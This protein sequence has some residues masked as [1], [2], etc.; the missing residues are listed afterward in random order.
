MS[1]MPAGIQID[2]EFSAG[3][4][5]NVTQY[6]KSTEGVSIKL[7]RTS[8]F[9]QPQVATCSVVL[10]NRTGNFTPLNAGGAYYPNV[11]P[12]KRIRVSYGSGASV[13]F[14][15]RIM[16][17]TPVVAGALYPQVRVEA[18]D[19]LNVLAGKTITGTLLDNQVLADQGSGGDAF[20]SLND[21]QGTTQ[22]TSRARS[23]FAGA[24]V[25]PM[26][27]TSGA[28]VTATSTATYDL[29][30]TSYASVAMTSMTPALSTNGNGSHTSGLVGAPTTVECWVYWPSND[31]GANA[32]VVVQG[33][34]GTLA[35][36]SGF[37]GPCV[38]LNASPLCTTSMSRGAWHH[39][40]VD[41][42][43]SA[44]KVYIDGVSQTVT[45]MAFTFGSGV[46]VYAAFRESPGSTSNLGISR[47]GV[48]QSAMSAATALTH[49]QMGVGTF[50]ELSG[51]RISRLRNYVSG[52]TVAGITLD[53]GAE[54]IGWQPLNGKSLLA[55]INDVVTSEGGGA[56]FYIAPTGF[57]RYIDRT[58][59]TTTTPVLTIDAS[60]DIN[61]DTWLPL[62]DAL[63]LITESTVTGTSGDFT[64]SVN[65]PYGSATDSVTTYSTDPLAPKR[66]AEY[67]VNSSAPAPRFQQLTVNIAR[68]SNS[69]TLYAA[70][71]NIGIGSRIR[72]INIPKSLTLADGTTT[73]IFHVD[74][75]DAYAEGWSE[76]ISDDNYIVTFDLSP[77][78]NPAR[79]VW[80][81][82][83]WQSDSG[84]SPALLNS[85]ITNAQT[86]IAVVA[87]YA[88][89]TT[90]GDYPLNIKVNEEI[91]TVTA[92]PASSTPPQ[93]LTVT[94]GQG[95]TFADAAANSAG[96][97]ISP[98]DSWTL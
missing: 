37:V 43:T 12:N 55:A 46:D 3:V 52:Y 5:T 8:E 16:S 85:A 96:V 86:T 54:T 17:W 38:T 33:P 39:I 42:T 45:P 71:A 21:S 1:N 40:V 20:W 92:A 66:L 35:I 78:N 81:T 23:L 34:S 4:W 97:Y 60:L 53:T 61:P 65:S 88:F 13:R 36:T 9:T 41:T 28:V 62:Y 7:G 27:V 30:A 19:V 10:D 64:Y 98:Y 49:Y 32:A 18:V 6:V 70:L 51:A 90:A 84:T 58:Y 93:T 22:Y 79:A 94:R 56:A 24:Y 59:R 25:P 91:M 80:D 11:K 2:I 57:M 89:S 76:Q 47:I 77:A 29:D 83:R 14:I 82:T 63:A 74:T 95:G 48:T 68:V 87:A 72:I 44:Q 67:R 73:R 75:I 31:D 69:T 50:T 26:Y 15:G